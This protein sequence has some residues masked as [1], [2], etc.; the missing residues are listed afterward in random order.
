VAAQSSSGGVQEQIHVRGW[1]RSGTGT[2]QELA[3]D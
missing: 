2:G 1:V 3:D